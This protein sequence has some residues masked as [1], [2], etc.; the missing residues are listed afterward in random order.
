MLL[1]ISY[2]VIDLAILA[3]KIMLCDIYKYLFIY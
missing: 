3:R 1:M 2:L